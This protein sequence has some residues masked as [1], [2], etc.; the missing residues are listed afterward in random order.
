MILSR[1][2][3]AVSNASFWDYWQND[4]NQNDY[5]EDSLDEMSNPVFWEK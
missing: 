4:I 2:Y 1:F 3:S 5:F